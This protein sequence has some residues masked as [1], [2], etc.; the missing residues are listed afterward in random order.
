MHKTRGAS[1]F[2][3]MKKKR[4]NR[5]GAGRGQGRKALPWYLK[6]VR[7]G[8][9]RI[10]KYK[11]DALKTLPVSLGSAVE[12]ALDKMY[13]ELFTKE[14]DRITNEIERTFEPPQ[15]FDE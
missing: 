5:G 11:L 14:R 3:P 6:K 2:L 9:L 10:T 1:P 12:Q 8:N 4:E 7:A 13:G 15:N